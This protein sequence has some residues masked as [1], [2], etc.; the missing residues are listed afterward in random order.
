[1]SWN[2][3]TLTYTNKYLYVGAHSAYPLTEIAF[4][5]DGTKLYFITDEN[6]IYQYALS[7]PWDVSTGTLE[8]SGTASAYLYNLSMTFKPDG[9]R[10]FIVGTNNVLYQYNLSTPWDISTI[11]YSG[12]SINLFAV[13]GRGGYYIDVD[14]KPDGTK[15]YVLGKTLNEVYQCSLSAWNITTASYDNKYLDVEAQDVEGI[16]VCIKPDGTKIYITGSETSKIYQYNLSTAWDIETAAYSFSGNVSEAGYRDAGSTY[17]DPDGVRVYVYIVVDAWD[18]VYQYAL[19]PD[20]PTNVQATKGVHTDKVVIT[21]D[22]VVGATGYKVYRDDVLVGGYGSPT[23][24]DVW[25]DAPTI[26]HGLITASD[27]SSTAHVVLSNTGALTNNGTT[28]TYKVT[29]TNIAGES[30]DSDTDTGYRG[31]GALTYQWYRSAGDSNASYSS[32]S[33]ATSSSYNDTGAPVPTITKGTVTA[34]DGTYADKVV[35]DASGYSTNVGAGRYYKCYHTATGATSGYT[36]V[37]RGYRG[38]GSLARQWQKSVGDSDASYS[39]IAGATS[40]PY[41]YTGAP[42][43]SVPGTPT[44]LAATD[45]IHTDKVVLTW[46]N[47]LG[48]VGAGR[49]YRAEYTASGATTQY[50]EGNRGYRGAYT[51]MDT[52]VKRDTTELGAI[53]SLQTSYN[54]VGADAP[55]ITAGTAS[56]SDGTNIYH[57]TLN[58]AGESA[59]IGTTHDYYV[60]TY[61]GAGWG[62]W[63]SVNTGYRGIGSLTYQW[64]RSASDSDADYSNISG[65][66]TDPYNDTGAP[67][68][69]NGRYYRCV[70][71]ADGA[72]QQIS[73]VDRGYR[74]VIV[75]SPS[76]PII[77][78]PEDFEDVTFDLPLFEEVDLGITFGRVSSAFIRR[79][80]TKKDWKTLREK[81]IIYQENM[82]QF[83]LTI[84]HNTL[85]LKN[86]VNDI[87]ENIDENVYPSDLRLMNQSQ[88]LTPL[89]MEEISPDGFKDIINDFRFK[90]VSNAYELNMNFRKLLHSLNSL[91]E[92]DYNVEP[93][94]YNMTEYI[95]IQPTAKRM[96]MQLEYMRRKSREVQRLVIINIKRIFTYV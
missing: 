63:C 81:C 12:N 26:T 10:V 78:F 31:V 3:S 48:E 57:V 54:D 61:N 93:I 18:S 11:G 27:G 37:N 47:V 30:E 75:I 86:L 91:A 15:M 69:G 56:A 74:S 58:V 8:A 45:G 41:N 65:A 2:I 40:D 1:M 33:G 35:L 29:A 84:N 66:T 46:T 72:A 90:D 28:H 22:A 32:I 95:D 36:G 20:A 82:N 76:V 83:T 9:T 38:V 51:S 25:A 62:S 34:T 44:G 14:F 87:I 13:I 4:K 64:Q 70:E 73:A 49:F 42:A 77:E 89:Y 96:I 60:R 53:G 21:W 6:K 43:G 23:A 92:S 85:V 80:D 68:N 88:H 24:N 94:S 39:N 7:T 50:T 17:I 16:S 67:E 59:N 52:Q 5:P 71:D 79:L 55:T 19:K